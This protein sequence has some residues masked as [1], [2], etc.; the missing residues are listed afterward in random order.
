MNEPAFPSS[1]I[2]NATDDRN[3]QR[4]G[5]TKLEYFAAAALTGDLA[6][7]SD[8]MGY[9]LHPYDSLAIRCFDVAEAM[10]AESER[11]QRVTNAAKENNGT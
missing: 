4:D 10:L 11:R 1:P 3:Q 5:L 9:F 6:A 2:P 7:Q 8:G